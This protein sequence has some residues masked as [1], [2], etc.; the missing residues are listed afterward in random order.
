VLERT[1]ADLTVTMRQYKLEA[2]LQQVTQR[3]S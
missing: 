2:A 1:R 3:L